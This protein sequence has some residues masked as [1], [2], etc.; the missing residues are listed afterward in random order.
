MTSGKSIN[1]R[2]ARAHVEITH[3]GRTMTIR[4]WADESGIAYHVLYSRYFLLGQGGHAL[5][6]E[7]RPISNGKVFEYQGESHSLSEWSRKLGIPAMTLI[8]R[9]HRGDTGERLFRPIDNRGRR[10]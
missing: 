4:D 8:R 7:V 5:F 1:P 9:Q 2:I 10:K 6:Q 3:G